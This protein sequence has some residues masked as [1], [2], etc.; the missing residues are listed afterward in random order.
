MDTLDSPGDP[1]FALVLRSAALVFNSPGRCSSA[2]HD[3]VAYVVKEPH[4]PPSGQSG[5]AR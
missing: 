4:G 3:E 5:I 1:P 2:P